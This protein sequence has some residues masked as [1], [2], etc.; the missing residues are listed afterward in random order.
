MGWVWAQ[1]SRLYLA[2]VVFLM[3][4]TVGFGLGHIA[5]FWLRQD[6]VLTLSVPALDIGIWFQCQDGG[7]CLNHDFAS[8]AGKA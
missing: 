3:L 7:G 6:A 1:R 4:A 5:P 2:G 8:D